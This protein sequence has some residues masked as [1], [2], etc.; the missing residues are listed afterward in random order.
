MHR[1][2]SVTLIWY[3]PVILQVCTLR[4]NRIQFVNILSH[5]LQYSGTNC[6]VRSKMMFGTSDALYV[7]DPRRCLAQVEVNASLINI[8]V[9]EILLKDK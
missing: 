2:P 7:R 9:I 3:L 1:L 5:T 8:I 6:T 4:L